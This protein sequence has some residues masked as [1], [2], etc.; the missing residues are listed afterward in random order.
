[1]LIQR[2]PRVLASMLAAAGIVLAVASCSHLAPLGPDVSLPQPHHLR[3]PFVLEAMRVQPP[4]PAGGCPAGYAALPGDNPSNPGPVSSG[5]PGVPR[6]A[7]QG[8]S[9]CYRKTGTPV[10][11]TSAAVSPVSPVSA[12]KPPPGQNAPAQYGFMITLPAADVPALTAVTTTAYHARGALAISIVGKT[13]ALPMVGGPFRGPQFQIP[14]PSRNQAL[15][16][17]RMLAPSG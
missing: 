15:Q 9:Q 2:P 17:Q 10:T 3:S 5:G 6:A 11:I 4:T 16:I 12:P 7:A 14:M 1:M 8:V 13:W